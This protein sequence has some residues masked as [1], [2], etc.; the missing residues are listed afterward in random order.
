[1]LTLIKLVRKI[2]KQ[3]KSDLTPTQLAIGAA[4]GTL[5]AL[6]PL[7][8]HLALLFTLALLANC[9]MAAF[10][11]VFGALKP[12]GLLL[13]T[14]SFAFG[15]ALLE[16]DGLYASV[17]EGL[18]DA[19]IL[20]YMGFDRYVV[21]G[22]YA[23]A[24]PVAVV[25]GAVV[26][27][28]VAKY[29]TVFAKKMEDAAWFQ[30]VTK[31]KVSAFFVTLIVGK[32]V[33]FVEKKPRFILLRPF[34][35][36][37]LAFIPLLY[38]GLT[39]GGGLY[40]QAAVQG[41]AAGSVS[42]ALGVQCTFGK[43]D[44]SFFGQR[45]AF[46][47]FQLPDP[48]DTRRD[49]LRIGGFEADLGFVSLLRKRL[50]I[51]KLAVR[52]IAANVTRDS[53]GKLNVTKVPGAQPK[54]PA[55]KQAWD[56]WLAWLTE[57][58]KNVDWTEVW[59]KYQ[60]YRRKAEAKKKEAEEEEK[61]TGKKP[62]LELAYD[63]DLRWSPERGDPML[64]ID[65]A[66][67]SNLALNVTDVPSLTSVSAK[68]E[69]MSSA[70]GWD[71]RPV[72]LTG[73]GALTSGSL[74]F[75]VSHLPGKTDVDLTLDGLPVVDYK[76]LYE[77]SL[78]VAV[79]AGKAG[80]VS[81]AGTADGRIDGTFD[82]T[83]H[84]LKI[85]AKPGETRILGLDPQ[86]SAYAIQGINAYG[87]KLPVALKA[88][89]KG[90]VDSPSID[91]TLPFLEIAKKGLQMLG[92]KELDGV[93]QKLDGEMQSLQKLGAEKLAPATGEAQKALE[94]LQKGDVTSAEEAARKAAEDAKKLPDAKQDLEKKKEELK[95]A[96]DLFKKKK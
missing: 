45:L 74:K 31:N 76:A 57:K 22:G 91:A 24:L 64:R 18:S 75:T 67:I 27:L 7:G 86:M 36:Y 66:E 2:F 38:V 28:L 8:L 43:V 92:R 25:T 87:E 59:N 93:I 77:K 19:P 3:I 12:V 70:P 51:E 56:E 26:R 35:P 68:G 89:V 44:Y 78:P 32:K 50:H 1:M 33:E 63:P 40:A 53:D 58:G 34:R 88:G 80:L 82:L 46:E 16:G 73:S 41:L 6:T 85:A 52:D 42:K 5:A 13:G 49:M 14:A 9:S 71:G 79:E 11:L 55:E 29:R 48:S 94:A 23:I 30:K 69:N 10:L 47:A 65:L 4:L 96:L 54:D 37:M 60:G 84:N 61:R 72:T 20:A 39:V 90:P 21:A 83:V 81:K 62:R 95:D 15:R 17:I